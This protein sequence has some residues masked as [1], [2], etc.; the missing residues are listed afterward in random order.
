[1]DEVRRDQARRWRS[2]DRILLEDYFQCCPE[3]TQS[4]EDTLV[5]II[6]EAL[7]RRKMGQEATV[8]DYQRRFPQLAVASAFNFNWIGCGRVRPRMSFRES[9]V[10]FVTMKSSGQRYAGG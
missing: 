10:L 6:G 2:G 1:M 9:Y 5:L 4:E 3:L 7:L 8:E